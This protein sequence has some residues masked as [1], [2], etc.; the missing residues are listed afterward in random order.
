MLGPP[1]RCLAA[2]HVLGGTTELFLGWMDGWDG[3][4]WWHCLWLKPCAPFSCYICHTH[5]S[6]ASVASIASGFN[7][8]SKPKWRNRRCRVEWTEQ[9]WFSKKKKEQLCVVCWLNAEAFWKKKKEG[10]WNGNDDKSPQAWAWRLN[11]PRV[12]SPAGPK[13]ENLTCVVDVTD[14][15]TTAIR[16]GGGAAA[17]IGARQ[18]LD[19]RQRGER[20]KRMCRL[21]RPPTPMAIGPRWPP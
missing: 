6:K 1:D 16:R 20:V 17:I 14:G 13:A 4:W 18:V 5:P 12:T 10:S 15:R 2:F 21:P 7:L 8:F 3:M 9:L 19:R 11:G